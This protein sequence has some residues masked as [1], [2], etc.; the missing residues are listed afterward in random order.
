MSKM[1]PPTHKSAYD[2]PMFTKAS[3]RLGSRKE[4]SDA[5]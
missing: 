4:G 3:A 5:D 1:P 2:F